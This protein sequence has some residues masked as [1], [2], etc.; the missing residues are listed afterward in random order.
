M[1][2]LHEIIA[3]ASGK[4][5]EVEKEI[6]EVYKQIQKPDLFDGIQRTYRPIA[7]DGEKLPAERK[8]VQLKTD[9]VIAEVVQ[10][11]TDLFDVT[12]TLDAG[13]QIAKGDV[14]VNGGAAIIEGV[15]VPTLLFL[16]KHL[17]DVKTFIE[18]LP[19]PDP[20]E[21][22]VHDPNSGSLVTPPVDTARTKKSAR[23]IVKYPATEQHPAQTEMI[24]EDILAGYWTTV[25]QTTKI[26]ADKKEAMLRRASAMIDAVKTARERANSVEVE[27]RKMGSAVLS[28]IFGGK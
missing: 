22:W 1:S 25:K 11:W 8:N 24:V 10:K 13:N 21:Q 20:S 15:P 14:T 17:K 5:G 3:V 28:Y 2:K 9:A 16:E 23:A 18:K 4:K 26:S 27:Q 12:L 6:T 19:T 7:E